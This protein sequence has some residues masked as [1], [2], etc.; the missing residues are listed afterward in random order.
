MET[1]QHQISSLRQ[2]L[3]M[4]SHELTG[5]QSSDAK[6]RSEL[7]IYEQ[8]LGQTK[9]NNDWLNEELSRKSNKSEHIQSLSNQ[10]ESC[11]QERNG[12]STR[13]IAFEKQ[14]KE[15]EIKIQSLIEKL[16]YTQDSHSVS[17][18]QFMSEMNSQKKLTEL[19]E[20]KL[21]ENAEHIQELN[22]L[23]KD[24]Q[25]QIESCSL[26]KKESQSQLEKQ[27]ISS[28]ERISK[29][30][31]E[32]TLLQEQLQAGQSLGNGG[33]AML[34]PSALAASQLQ[35]SGKTFTQVVCFF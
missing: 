6:L 18:K 19:Y 26:D 35:K 4:A 13:V 2:E 23:V 21:S 15:M 1:L 5:V 8:Q 17:E 11:N 14:N 7:A 30:E 20:L 12:L 22:T 34:S 32:L 33:L 29:L 9:R 24:L 28:R 3:N 10:L 31:S 27:L 25:E 16:K